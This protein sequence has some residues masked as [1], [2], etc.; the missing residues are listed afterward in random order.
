MSN[1]LNAFTIMETM[2]ALVLT[3][4]VIV[5]VYS[6]IGTLLQQADTLAA[7]LNNFGE[8]NRLQQALM[9]DNRDAQTLYFNGESV[10]FKRPAINITYVLTDSLCIRKTELTSDTFHVHV[11]STAF[12]FEGS[13]QNTFGGM[14]DAGTIF[15]TKSGTCYPITFA[16]HYGSNTLI[17]YLSSKSQP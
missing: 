16:K 2:V 10:E 3:G 14:V 6:S 13:R 12:W 4:L 8:L 9:T 7:K 15:I 5:M 11:D 17:S 1:K